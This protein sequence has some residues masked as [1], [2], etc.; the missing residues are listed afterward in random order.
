[1]PV[2]PRS[3]V[4]P[5]SFFKMSPDDK[6]TSYK[7]NLKAIVGFPMA[8]DDKVALLNELL[9]KTAD[10]IS[11]ADQTFKAAG[12]F[13]MADIYFEIANLAKEQSK[14]SDAYS[15]AYLQLTDCLS[16]VG[17]IYA[18]CE[19]KI[20]EEWIRQF[21][22]KKLSD[23]KQAQQLADDLFLDDLLLQ[24]QDTPTHRPRSR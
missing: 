2:S 10:A 3:S 13:L 16:R 7:A 6:L 14:T 18:T 21:N 17:F 22:T 9:K 8:F 24:T 4:S 19:E 23:P 15:N 11:Q 1:M 5:R 20:N 12:L